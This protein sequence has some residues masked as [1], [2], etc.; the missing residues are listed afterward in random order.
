MYEPQSRQRSTPRGTLAPHRRHV[1]SAGVTKVL[2]VDG[3][4]A[5]VGSCFPQPEQ[6]SSSP[7]TTAPHAGHSW[8]KTS[9]DQASTTSTSRIGKFFWRELHRG[10]RTCRSDT[11]S[12]PRVLRVRHGSELDYRNTVA[13]QF[14][15]KRGMRANSSG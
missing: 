4:A 14:H 15:Q 1:C 11:D 3:A 5:A 12:A 8:I 9:I 7:M 2:A 6:T 10:M 13:R